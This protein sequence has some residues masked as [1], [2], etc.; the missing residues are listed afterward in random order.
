KEEIEELL[1]HTFE[2]LYEKRE[3]DFG[4]ELMREIERAVVLQ[5]VD[6]RWKDHL[7]A[8][9]SLREGIGL[10][11]YG[12]K[13]PLIEYKNEAFDMFQSMIEAIQEDVVTYIMRVTPKI[14]GQ[15]PEQPR[16]V[17][18][19]RYEDQQAVKTPRRVGEQI[20]RNDPCPCGSGKKYKKCCGANK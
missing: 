19:N 9:D 13:D 18:E 16:N 6:T 12:Q 4:S 14:T 10:R 20:G 2:E 17:S 7:A 3:E 8:M 11:A 15:A 5:V 1:Y